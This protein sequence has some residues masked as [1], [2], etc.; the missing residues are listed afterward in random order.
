[1]TDAMLASQRRYAEIALK[2]GVQVMQVLHDEVNYVGPRVKV[3]AFVREAFVPEEW[4]EQM[5]AAFF[6]AGHGLCCVQR[7]IYTFGLLTNVRF[8]SATAYAFDRR[9]CYDRRADVVEALTTWD[10]QGDPPGEW[11]K[12]KMSGRSRL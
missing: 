7:F 6:V 11:I 9:Y 2:H 12:E 3:A 1:M 8:N 10:G 5:V 4:R